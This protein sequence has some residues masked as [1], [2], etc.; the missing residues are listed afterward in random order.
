M[1]NIKKI[2]LL[3]DLPDMNKG[4]VWSNDENCNYI[5]IILNGILIT[6]DRDYLETHKDWFQIEYATE[7]P[8]AITLYYRKQVPGAQ[9]YICFQKDLEWSEA[10]DK[11][12]DYLETHADEWLRTHCTKCGFPK[13]IDIKDSNCEV[14]DPCAGDS[15]TECKT[16]VY[17]CTRCG[18]LS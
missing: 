17:R 9:P 15:C 7:D 13:A 10:A 2:T 6:L 12:A 18:S 3:K 4:S 1:K 8:Y 16:K 11:L 14:R 5:R